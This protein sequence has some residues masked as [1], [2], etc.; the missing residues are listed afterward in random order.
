V[1]ASTA[2]ILISIQTAKQ[3]MK[4]YNQKQKNL[5]VSLWVEIASGNNWKKWN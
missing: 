5:R 2:I 4:I 3:D 1:L